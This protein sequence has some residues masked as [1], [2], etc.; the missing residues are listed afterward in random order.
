MGI[1]MFKTYIYNLMKQYNVS[2]SQL[3]AA[4]GFRS[5]NTFYRLVNGEYSVEK[6]KELILRLVQSGIFNIT[7]D[8]YD[9][10]CLYAE[11]AS[12]S[13]TQR[14]AEE[15]FISMY[16]KMNT[17]QY[18]FHSD[19][20]SVTLKDILLHHEGEITIYISGIENI[21]IIQDMKEIFEAD[22]NNNVTVYHLVNFNNSDKHIAC[23]IVS[24][25]KLMKYSQYNPYQIHTTHFKGMAIISETANKSRVTIFE[26]KGNKFECLN[27]EVSNDICRYF[28]KKFENLYKKEEKIKHPME[29]VSDIIYQIKS[30][31]VGEINNCITLAG[32]P[33]F[34]DVP[35]EI[36]LEMLKDAN[37]MGFPKDNEFIAEITSDVKKRNELRKIKQA[38]TRHI[39][40][41]ERMIHFF[42]NYRIID[43]V[44]F[45]RSFSNAEMQKL[46]ELIC[47]DTDWIQFR[48]LKDEFELNHCEISFIEN[49]FVYMWDSSKGYD[50]GHFA[51]LI[52]D[53]RAMNLFK[54]CLYK[55]WDEYSYNETE[56]KKIMNNLIK[57]YMK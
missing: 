15:I 25:L 48:F 10:L 27:S 24:L 40:T 37:Y 55:L 5:R 38:H 53:K 11:E 13:K 52:D 46:M 47:N 43:H 57:I 9:N 56:S 17:K 29:R 50:N 19:N 30:L 18:I 20:G 51:S 34:G 7:K 4:L 12:V 3:S 54:S 45:F 28:I 39:F 8:E 21:S 22:L 31:T 41:R 14:E 42:K 6:T 49:E 26:K 32:T 36:W 23:N 35:A 2:I 1:V 16:K 33:C 44:G